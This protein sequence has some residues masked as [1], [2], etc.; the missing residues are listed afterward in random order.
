MASRLGHAFGGVRVHDGTRAAASAAAVG[1]SAYAIGPHVVF[2]AGRYA[3]GTSAG[4]RLLAHELVHVAQQERAAPGPGG[5]EIA[6]ADDPAEREAEAIA[7]GG[8]GAMGQRAPALMRQLADPPIE[9]MEIP[10][11]AEPELEEREREEEEREVGRPRFRDGVPSGAFEEIEEA[12]DRIARDQPEPEPS[13]EEPPLGEE[14]GPTAKEWLGPLAPPWLD[15]ARIELERP[16]VTLAR[17]GTASNFI[18]NEA[19]QV[20]RFQWHGKT[21]PVTYAPRRLH[22]IDAIEHEV[23]HAH[24]RADLNGILSRYL[25]F[26][27]ERIIIDPRLPLIPPYFP[28]DFDPKGEERRRAFDRAVGSRVAAE[29]ALAT[30]HQV[31]RRKRTKKGCKIEW[32]RAPLGG[33][34]IADAFSFRYCQNN[35]P[36]MG[37]VRVS[38]PG[39]GGVEVDSVQYDGVGGDTA[40]ECKCGYEWVA[41]LYY[42]ADP[43]KRAR[44]IRFLEQPMAD[45]PGRARRGER[46][47]LIVQLLHQQRVAAEC[48]LALK[49]VV[50]SGAFAQVL[51]EWAPSLMIDCQSYSDCG[52]GCGEGPHP[53]TGEERE[54][55]FGPRQLRFDR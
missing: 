44:A 51:S 38:V 5:V 15:R 31:T 53:D 24:S 18:T 45:E 23:A 11:E 13:R 25:G 34:P 37:E 29:P 8:A 32:G 22:V 4:D 1:A 39:P 43:R 50:S 33:H 52:P 46:A 28:A 21:W 49:Y 3:P 36:A 41:D 27:P 6:R 26:W 19:P 10:E 9:P 55:Q 16:V 20:H 42:S 12:W 40:Y 48:G 30:A 47:G 17:G 14:R 54:G 7:R 2:G 35:D